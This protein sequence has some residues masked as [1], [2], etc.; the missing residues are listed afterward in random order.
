MDDVFQSEKVDVYYYQ[1][2][3][4]KNDWHKRKDNKN[5]KIYEP[6]IFK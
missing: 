5:L 2:L 4:F 3:I 6:N 1:I